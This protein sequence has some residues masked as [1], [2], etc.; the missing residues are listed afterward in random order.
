MP[1]K[2]FAKKTYTTAAEIKKVRGMLGLT[3]AEFADLVDISK[4]TIERW[5]TSK[6]EITGPIVLLIEMLEENT[7]Y[8]ANLEIPEK[9]YP[10]R[11]W[12]MYKNK[13]CTLIDVDEHLKKIKIKN[14]VTNNVFK[15]FGVN[16]N[17]SFEDYNK[18]LES[19]CFA[20]SRDKLKL[21]LDD[22]NLPFYD[23]LMIIEKTEGRMAEDDFWI[24]IEK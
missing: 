15:A 1:N 11:M 18:F 2:T 23:P 14:F 24:K 16:E 13:A 5:E 8:V 10:I 4:P 22:L 12:Y 3:Q 19:R 6:K 21:I 20:D 7:D 17:P 9:K